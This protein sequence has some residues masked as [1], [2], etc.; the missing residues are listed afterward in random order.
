M[1]R[2]HVHVH[3]KDID[4]SLGFYSTLFGAQ[5]DVRKPDYAK[6]MLNDPRVNFAISTSCGEPGVSHLGIQVDEA[7]ELD[8][9]AGQLKN[10]GAALVE[11]EDARCCYARGDKV[12][13]S[14]PQDV[15]WETFHTKGAI[16][17][18]GED[19]APRSG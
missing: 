8:A 6:W 11:Q 7:A 14:D 18:F 3:V 12:W 9:I 19:G 1:K 2:L 13:V 5:P 4:Q 10:A 17:T 16:T 15:A